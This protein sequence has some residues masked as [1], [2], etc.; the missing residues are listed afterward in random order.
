MISRGYTGLLSGPERP[1]LHGPGSSWI[2]LY[3]RIYGCT[4][5]FGWERCTA[6]TA[7]TAIQLYTATRLYSQSSY[8]ANT[9]TRLY[10]QYGYT[11]VLGYTAIQP[12]RLYSQYGYTAVLGYTANTA[13]E[14][15]G[16][17]RRSLT[18]PMGT[19]PAGPNNPHGFLE[20]GYAKV[21]T[22]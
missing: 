1:W 11:A 20:Q 3:S 4:R 10:S 8:T 18:I 6:G 16:I 12:I 7:N 13:S 21:P 17:V 22:P 15:M 9:A 14:P 19:S 2:R 5:G